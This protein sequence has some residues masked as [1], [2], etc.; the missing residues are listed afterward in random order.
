M[1]I[2]LVCLARFFCPLGSSSSFWLVED[3]SKPSTREESRLCFAIFV[4]T[5]FTYTIQLLLRAA[6]TVRAIAL[7]DQKLPSDLTR[8]IQEYGIWMAVGD[9]NT[10]MGAD[11]ML[12]TWPSNMDV[13]DAAI[14]HGMQVH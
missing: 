4:I 5:P 13:L 1:M 2:S 6:R 12:S 3:H 9:E 7:Q 14:E 8:N 11:I 10:P